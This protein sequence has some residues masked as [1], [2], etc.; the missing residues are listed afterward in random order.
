VCGGIPSR[1][2]KPQTQTYVVARGLMGRGRSIQDVGRAAKSG[3][4]FLEQIWL[5][6]R[7]FLNI[8][9]QQGLAVFKMQV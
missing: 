1:S 3:P 9:F 8:N 2:V 6:E 5:I 7:L 4:T